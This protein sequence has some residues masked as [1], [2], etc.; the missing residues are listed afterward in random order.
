[1]DGLMILFPNESSL[2]GGIK[3]KKGEG[4]NDARMTKIKAY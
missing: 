2:D 4:K 3:I 1:M